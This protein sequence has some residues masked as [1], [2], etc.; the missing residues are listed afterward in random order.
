MEET[1][2]EKPAGNGARRPTMKEV[3]TLAGVSLATVSRVINADGKVRS[4]LAEKV[5]EAVSLLG[6]RRDFT[7]TNL[8]RANRAS[9]S[10]G[11]VFDDVANPFHAAVLRGVETVAR[12]RGV[13]PLVGSSDEDPDRERE[14]A[15]A[16]LSRRVDGLVVVPTGA[17]HSY[18]R[19]ERD[20]GV[21]LV[22]VDRPPAFIDADCVLSDNA[23]GA[24]AATA[25]L[26]AAGHRRIGFLGDRQRIFTAGERLRG[27]REALAVHGVAFDERLVRMELHDSARAAAA[28]AGLLEEDDPPTAL[29][30]AQNLISI[31]AIQRLRQL[32]LHR[33]VALVGFDDLTLADALD[34]GLTVIAQDA[35]ELGRMTAELL[36][37]RLDG[38]NG[39]S[40][41]VEIPTR[42][43]ERGTG[44]LRP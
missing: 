10:I 40:R 41:R 12:M 7:A 1:F 3:A 42:L 31:G 32:D 23:G 26:L 21:A 9:A 30:S 8:R 6:Y 39:P 17:D 22:F 5:H 19:L 29:F 2:S 35:N 14:L 24:F 44:E 4:D 13:L 16:F 15:E 43:I 33:R 25:H 18:L 36:F 11:L 27:Y 38:R 28:V 34:P 20:A 37:A